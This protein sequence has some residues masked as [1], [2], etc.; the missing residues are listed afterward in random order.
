[1]YIWFLTKIVNKYKMASAWPQNLLHT[2]NLIDRCGK[3][4]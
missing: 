4:Y 2:Y 3:I 1:M